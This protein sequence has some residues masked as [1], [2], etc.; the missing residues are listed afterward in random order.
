MLMAA[1]MA[2]APPFPGPP[3]ASQPRNTPL[4]S[5]S[6]GAA[7]AGPCGRRPPGRAQQVPPVAAGAPVV[8]VLVVHHGLAAA[9]ALLLHALLLHGGC[10][11]GSG[12]GNHRPPPMGPLWARRGSRR[13]RSGHGPAASQPPAARRDTLR[14]SGTRR[15]PWGMLGNVVL[16]GRAAIGCVAGRRR[17]WWRAARG[18]L[19]DGG[20]AGVA[21][22]WD[23]VLRCPCPGT[24]WLISAWEGC[25]AVWV[26]FPSEGRA[27]G[28]TP[29]PGPALG[30][31]PEAPS[32]SSGKRAA[33]K[34]KIHVRKTP[35]QGCGCYT[36]LP[37]PLMVCFTAFRLSC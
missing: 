16:R 30:V 10:L 14:R 36:R 1:A 25:P 2:P 20:G 27:A 21:A 26:P 3:P 6:S 15:A 23:G 9:A 8:V 32:P 31:R 24:L 37:T 22:R 11:A 19:W 13:L 12:A 34:R 33:G 4:C 29:R 18:A 28:S 5:G 35:K 17:G 7:A